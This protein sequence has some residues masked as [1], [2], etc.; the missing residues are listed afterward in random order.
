MIVLVVMAH[1]LD[2]NPPQSQPGESYAIVGGGKA[3][4]EWGAE[5]VVALEWTEG[6]LWKGIVEVPADSPP[7]EFKVRRP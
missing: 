2:R 4:G 1:R 7:P 6:G 5:S 3:L